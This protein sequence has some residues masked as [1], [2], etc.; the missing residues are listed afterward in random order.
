M[1]HS[2]RSDIQRCL[3]THMF[4]PQ[5][6]TRVSAWHERCDSRMTTSV[7]TPSSPTITNTYDF[8]ACMR[9]EKSCRSGDYETNKCSMTWMPTSSLSYVSCV[10]QPPIYS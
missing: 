7:T 8:N 9:L 2:C 3:E 4:D 6:T 10:C 5:F 1:V